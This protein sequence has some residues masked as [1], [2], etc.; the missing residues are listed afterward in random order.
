MIITGIGPNPFP[1]F[2][3]AYE[4]AL[5]LLAQVGEHDHQ[6]DHTCFRCSVQPDCELAAA[7]AADDNRPVVHGATTT[8]ACW[9]CRDTSWC[10]VNPE[11]DPRGAQMGA[12]MPC[13]NCLPEAYERWSNGHYRK[14]HSCEICEDLRRRGR[15]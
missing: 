5:D 7:Q 11:I 8:F 12:V 4:A 2:R 13:A 15:S 10:D 14:G 9:M 1:A 6:P 3:A